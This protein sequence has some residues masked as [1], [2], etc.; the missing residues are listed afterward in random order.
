MK[1]LSRITDKI[2][3]VSIENS[4]KELQVFVD[5]EFIPFEYIRLDGTNVFVVML[6]N[7]S[8]EFEIKRIESGYAV[9][10]D[11]RAFNCSVEDKRLLS[12]KNAIRQETIVPSHHEIRSPMPGL[13][14]LI[15]VKVGDKVK[16]GQGLVII[17]AMKMENEIKAP[18]DAVVTEIKVNPKEAVDMNQTLLILK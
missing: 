4:E 9:N 13:I 17:E 8:F 18:V 16:A 12:M 3:D 5:G 11:G 2:F 1:Y 10:Y 14:V 7:R 6:E 15:E